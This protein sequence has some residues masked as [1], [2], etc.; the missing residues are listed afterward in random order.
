M[1]FSVRYCYKCNE[2]FVINKQFLTVSVTITPTT[3]GVI[4]GIKL[5]VVLAIPI[6]MPAT[7]NELRSDITPEEAREYKSTL[8]GKSG[9]EVS[10]LVI[11]TTATPTFKRAIYAT[12]MSKN[13]SRWFRSI[14]L[15]E[16]DV[17]YTT[18]LGKRCKELT[19]SL[20][21]TPTTN[22]VIRGIKLPKALLIPIS[23]K[24]RGF[25][26]HPIVHPLLTPTATVIIAIAHGFWPSSRK[27]IPTKATADIQKAHEL[28]NKAL[29]IA[30][31]KVQTSIV[32][33]APKRLHTGPPGNCVKTN[34][35][36]PPRLERHSVL[37]SFFTIRPTN[38]G[39]KIGITLAEVFTIPISIPA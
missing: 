21:I 6:S 5:T 28:G 26:I 2:E 36:I 14:N 12:T 19:V 18:L 35:S 17:T 7:T 32:A 10:A 25:K 30:E 37:T 9:F 4:M 11:A 34:H 15:T 33:L 3:R 29:N 24:S 1:V 23:D 27:P 13:N 8:T 31:H 16:T 20:T 22:G 38:N 39:V